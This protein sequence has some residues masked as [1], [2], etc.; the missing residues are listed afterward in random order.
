MIEIV[1]DEDALRGI[2]PGA[3]AELARRGTDATYRN[4]APS[5]NDDAFIE[6]VILISTDSVTQAARNPHQHLAAAFDGKGL[7]GFV[8]ATVHDEQS[9]EM[10][11]L[12][13]DPDRHGSGIAGT[14]MRAGM[15]WLGMDRPMWLNV[16]KSNQRA[17]GFYRKHG[18]EIDPTAECA[19]A[20]PHWIMRRPAD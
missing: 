8:I 10:D 15:E 6:R 5:E 14:L 20:M 3:V 12:F 9:R 2:A 4:E 13:V 19:H 18:F 11:W 17:I 7:A 16:A 1:T